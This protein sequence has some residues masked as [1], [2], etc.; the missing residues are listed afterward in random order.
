MI[1]N[2]LSAY[3]WVWVVDPLIAGYGRIIELDIGAYS[4]HY[5]LSA[6]YSHHK[7]PSEIVFMYIARIKCQPTTP[8][9]LY[10][11]YI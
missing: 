10:I 11:Y 9:N 6:L 8:T 1:F 4:D 3:A 5:S 2:L 7:F